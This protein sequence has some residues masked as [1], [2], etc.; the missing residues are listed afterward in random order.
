[1]KANHTT[2]VGQEKQKRPPGEEG[3][4]A[5]AD[6]AV[7]KPVTG[8]AGGLRQLAGPQPVPKDF[9]RYAGTAWSRR[10]IGLQ[11]GLHASMKK[12]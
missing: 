1:M 4:F 3:H 7:P 12:S 11:H 9:L 8:V 2:A 6:G 5:S 10:L